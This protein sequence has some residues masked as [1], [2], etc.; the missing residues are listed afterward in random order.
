M[1]QLRRRMTVLLLIALITIALV[2]DRIYAFV[3][4]TFVTMCIECTGFI[5]L[6][7]TGESRILGWVA[8]PAW[9]VF[10]GFWIFVRPTFLMFGK[11]PTLAEDLF[12][13]LPHGVNVLVL[14]FEP[15]QY[16]LR[17]VWPSVL[18][19]ATYGFFLC[20][21]HWL[22]GRD[23]RGNLVYPFLDFDK[24]FTPLLVACTPFLVAGIHALGTL[25]QRLALLQ[26]YQPLGQNA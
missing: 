26:P 11:T 20:V 13:L 15:P 16:A 21:Y 10:L 19:T 23:P 5:Q 18:Y 17:S 22:G 3:Y 8:A 6:L 25:Q 12:M 9:A 4:F 14:L 1:D 24:P 7:I 2:I